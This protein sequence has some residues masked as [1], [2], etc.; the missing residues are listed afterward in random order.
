MWAVADESPGSTPELGGARLVTGVMEK[1]AMKMQR[2]VSVAA[3]SAACGFGMAF[4]PEHDHV[5]QLKAADVVPDFKL[6]ELWF[7][8]TAPE[9]SIKEFVKGEPVTG[10]E[11]GRVYVVEFWATWCG[12]CIAAFPHLSDLQ[13]KYSED[14]A[15]VGVNIWERQKGEE[16]METVRQFV[17]DN[18]EIMRYT[19]AIEKDTEMA[20][21]WMKAAGQNGIPASFIVDQSGKIAWM[22]HPMYIDEPLAAVV[23]GEWDFAELATE[24]AVEHETSALY[25]Y[26]MK[27][28]RSGETKVSSK[29][30]RSL[31]NHE[32]ADNAQGLNALAWTVATDPTE[33]ERDLE[34][35]LFMAKKG[36]KLT[37]D[38]DPMILDTLARVY[39]ELEKFDKAVKIQA[40]AVKLIGDERGSDG[41]GEALE[42]YKQA[43]LDGKKDG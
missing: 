7:G 20:D 30:M 41:M 31:A 33:G 3:L 12:P 34:L 10:F 19:V 26:A 2:V 35:A 9:M 16:R 23:A 40:K 13:E 39:F 4:G 15:F 32:F 1:Q 21:K 42:K 11:A 8:S 18:D 28:F 38:K 29:I 36:S 24:A 17:A 43:V 22:G 25:G 6:P 27:A 37:D 14:V 5:E